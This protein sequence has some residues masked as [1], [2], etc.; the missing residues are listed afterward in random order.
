[1]WIFDSCYKGCVE[2]RGRE[3]SLTKASVAYPPLFY[4]H[5]KDPPEH[6]EMIEALEEPLQSRRVKLQNH[7]GTL[8]GHRIYANRKV[9][10]KIEIQTR[11]QAELYDVGR[12][13]GSALHGR[14]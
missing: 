6:K 2:L 12:P 1:M 14:A 13:P 3:R 9:A 10:E 8:Q 5:P 7:L 4:M 11:H